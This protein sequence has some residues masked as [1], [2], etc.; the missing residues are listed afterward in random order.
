MAVGTSS[1]A[2][3]RFAARVATPAQQA[4]HV[5][6]LGETK[7]GAD[8]AAKPAKDGVGDVLH[9]SQNGRTTREEIDERL[10]R[11]SSPF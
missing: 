5:D 6:E 2:Q 9:R 11:Q 7:L 10:R 1:G 4:L 3:R 8:T